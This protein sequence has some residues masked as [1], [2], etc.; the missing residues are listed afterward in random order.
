MTVRSFLQ[1]QNPTALGNTTC[2]EVMTVCSFRTFL[3]PQHSYTS[4]TCEEHGRAATPR[5]RRESQ[6]VATVRSFS[7]FR[8]LAA[9]ANTNSK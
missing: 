7:I 9:H 4:C 3:D 6:T 8:R 2:S 5:K 1:L